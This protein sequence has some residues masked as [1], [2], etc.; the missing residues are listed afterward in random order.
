M[1]MVSDKRKTKSQLIAELEEL[2]DQL[3]KTEGRAKAYHARLRQLASQLTLA[4]E[5]QRRQLAHDLHDCIGNALAFA[6]LKVDAL[7]DPRTSPERSSLG[8]ISAVL[9]RTIEDSH[10]LMFE[11]S[12]PVLYE[13]GLV[14][15]IVWL[16]NRYRQQFAL[17]VDVHG[18]HGRVPLDEDRRVMLYRAVKELLTNVVKHAG[19]RAAGVTIERHAGDLSIRVED[20]GRGF[21]GEELAAHNDGCGRF[22]LFSVRERLAHLG[23]RCE[24]STAPGEGTRVSLTTPLTH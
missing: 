21:C 7:A 14:A 19:T 15:A 18:E 24:I 2:R 3:H 20:T 9:K 8:E 6:K 5:R 4:E 23:I 17:E 13:S 12:P 16:A 1:A 11:L 22:G 10:S